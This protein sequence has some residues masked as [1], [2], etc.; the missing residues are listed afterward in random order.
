M[1]CNK[2]DREDIQVNALRNCLNYRLSDRVSLVDIHKSA[3]LVSL[4]QR[5]CIQL[6]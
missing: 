1:A 2:T 3:N 4:E 5:Q 6:L